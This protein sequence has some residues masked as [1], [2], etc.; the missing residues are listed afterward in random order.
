MA[1]MKPTAHT[2]ER[3]RS[4]PWYE[5]SGV[6]SQGAIVLLHAGIADSRMWHGQVPAL[7]RSFRVLSVDMRGFGRSPLLSGRVDRADDVR[8][9]LDD[10]GVLR[11]W[12]V[13]SSLGGMVALEF[14]IRFPDRVEGLVLVAPGIREWQSSADVVELGRA[15][16]E[17]LEAGDEERAVDLVARFWL[18]GT[19]RDAEPR[20]NLLA[21]LR[22]MQLDACRL[23][24][25]DPP[26][27]RSLP[28][29]PPTLERLSDVTVPTLVVVGEHDIADLQQIASLLASK[30][31]NAERIVLPGAAHLP[32][33]ETPAAFNRL[34]VD[35]LGRPGRT[36]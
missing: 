24:D 23:P 14:A 6:D 19:R 8:T 29:D 28:L 21:L 16:D 36:V 31:P 10:A 35:Y 18:R 13:G 4:L 1:G 5:V 3:V 12:C 32:P 2:E 22:T 7:E 11:A 15:E 25:P 9:V 17:A 34:L 20:A 30:L 26:P 27:E 33:L